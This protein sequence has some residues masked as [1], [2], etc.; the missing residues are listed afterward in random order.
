MHD[1]YTHG[2]IGFDKLELLV[3][4]CS[5]IKYV[6][7]RKMMLFKCSKRHMIKIFEI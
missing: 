1:M 6:T 3:T 4:G 2:V 5:V 7:N